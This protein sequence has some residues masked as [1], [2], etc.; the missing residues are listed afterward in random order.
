MHRNLTIAGALVLVLLLGI[1][2]AGVW[3]WHWWSKER[4][5]QLTIQHVL[6]RLEEPDSAYFRDVQYFPATG[7]VCGSVN[8][9]KSLG[10]YIGF[11]GFVGLKSGDVRFQP[12]VDSES[13]DW[14]IKL[15]AIREEV[16]FLKVQFANC[17]ERPY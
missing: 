5:I 9:R 13:P 3:W 12:M 15:A 7:A 10:P 11:R 2:S 8:S 17:P 16:A 6:D 4:P 14:Q 1:A